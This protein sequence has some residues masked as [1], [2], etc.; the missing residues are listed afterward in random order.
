MPVKP[1]TIAVSACVRLG[2]D[3]RCIDAQP[4][5]STAAHSSSAQTR[6]CSDTRFMNDERPTRQWQR[7]EPGP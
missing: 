1:G 2:G 5:A 3:R 6:T 4:D 7:D